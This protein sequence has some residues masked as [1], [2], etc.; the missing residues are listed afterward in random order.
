MDPAES[1]DGQEAGQP[2]EARAGQLIRIDHESGGENHADGQNDHER[3]EDP[4][5]GKGSDQEASQGRPDGGGEHDDQGGHPHG[6][7]QPLGRHDLH[8]HGEHHRQDEAGPDPLDGPPSQSE[9]EG[10]GEAGDEGSQKEGPQ[11]DQ[12]QAFGLEPLHED[13]GERQ[14]DADD[15]HI[16]DDQPLGEGGFHPEGF[17]QLRKGDVQGGLAVHAGETA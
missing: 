7:A 4:S 2:I 14:D 12:G 8:D 11:G 9:G 16:A 17:G 13:A 3:E 15:Q 10:G 1:D 5:P 6:G